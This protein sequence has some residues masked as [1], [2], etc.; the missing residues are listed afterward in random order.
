MYAQR[1]WPFKR[2]ISDAQKL[3]NEQ[4]DSAM[5]MALEVYLESPDMRTHQWEGDG[6]RGFTAADPLREAWDCYFFS[7]QERAATPADFS[8]FKKELNKLSKEHNAKSS[9]A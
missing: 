8:V 2:K 7:M 4:H 9:N 6:F 5:Q 1:M 3:R